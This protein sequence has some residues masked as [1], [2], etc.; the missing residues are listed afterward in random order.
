MEEK[1]KLLLFKYLYQILN[2]SLYER[3]LQENNIDYIDKEDIMGETQKLYSC[4]SKYFYLLN[5]IELY[6]LSQD[7]KIYLMNLD[8]NDKVDN[9]VEFFIKNTLSRV[10]M[11][12]SSNNVTY[13]GPHSYRF[14][15][16]NNQIVLG[17]KIDEFGFAH[18][19][20][21]SDDKMLEEQKIIDE[22]ISKIEEAGKHLNIK[23]IK[24][25]ELF[26]KMYNKGK[27]L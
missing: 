19:I 22:I 8:L 12:N 5:E 16:R 23:I 11:L 3:L 10:L 15:A 24:Y 4:Y 21:K 1:Y 17:L 2:L 13:Y 6:K 14:K 18:E 27:R 9:K 25:N 7:E 20:I 26:E